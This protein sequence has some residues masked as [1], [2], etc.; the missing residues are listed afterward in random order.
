MMPAMKLSNFD[1]VVV[2][3]RISKSGNAMPQSGDLQGSRSPVST[4]ETQTIE[5]SIDSRVE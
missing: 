4:T 3:A 5:I 1:Q 2:G